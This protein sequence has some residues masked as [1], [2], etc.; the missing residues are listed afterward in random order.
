MFIGSCANNRISDLRLAASIAKGRTVAPNVTAWVVPGSQNVKR[1]AEAE[2]LD[3]VFEDAGFHWAEPGCSMCGGQGHG[4][5]EILK[6]ATR[7]VSTINRN[8]PNRQGPGSITHLVSPPMAAA[9]AVTGAIT[10]VRK[11]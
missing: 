11:L 5:T 7:A 4:F 8:F 2:G 9:A 6:R 3:R 1:Q 10:D